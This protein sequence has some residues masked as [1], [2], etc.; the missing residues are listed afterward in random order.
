M[1]RCLQSASLGLISLVWILLLPDLCGASPRRVLF[2][3]S[4]HPG[5]PTFF[6]QVEGITAVL[7][8][9]KILLDVEFMDTKR[10]PGRETLDLFYRSLSRKI[11]RL[12]PYDAII[13]GDDNAL[14]FAL[15]HQQDLFAK[16]PIVFF[17][18]NDVD[19]A[20]E[21]IGNPLVTGTV[22]AVSMQETLELM[23]RLHP[24][25]K[26]VFALVDSTPSGQGDL[27][28][29]QRLRDEMAPV[30]LAEISLTDLSFGE[31]GTRLRGLGEADLVLLLSAYNDSKGNIL[32]FDQSLQLI[33]QNLS[34]PLYHLWYHGIGEGIFG[35]KVI[36]H[37]EQGR[38]AAGVVLEIFEGRPVSEIA[39]R[40]ASPNH[41][42]FDY[43]ELQRFGL[44][45]KDLPEDSLILN[46][47]SSFYQ[48]YK[49][50][51][52]AGLGVILALAGVTCA[53]S[54]HIYYRRQ[55]E[56][57]LRKSESLF[58]GLIDFSPVP[59]A[60]NSPDGRVEYLNSKFVQ[61]FGYSRVDIPDVE[62]WWIKA[63]PDENYRSGVMARWQEAI[64]EAA[65]DGSEIQPAEYLV[66]CKDGSTR[67]VEIFGALIGDKYLIVLNDI[68]DRKQAEEALQRALTETEEGRDK[69]AAIL[70]SV[71][72]GL[73]FTDMDNRVVLMSTSAQT[74]LGKSLH[75]IF[76]QPLDAVIDNG[77]LREQFTALHQGERNQALVE[78]SLGAE[79][80]EEVRTVQAKS[81]PVRRGS[82]VRAGVIT[83]LR[84][85]TLERKLDAMKNEFISTAAHELRTPLT[86]VK[87]FADLLLHEKGFSA[88][89][90]DEYLGIIFEKSQVL[91]EIIDDLLDLS[92]VESGRLV[93]LEKGLCDLVAVV[94]RSIDQYR[95][96][97]SS[98]RFEA[99]LPLGGLRLLLDE[100][101]MVQVMENLL[102]NAVKFSTRGGLIRI[103]C[104]GAGAE[105]RFSVED[106]GIGMTPEQIDRVFDK[107][108]RADTSDTAVGGL[109]LGMAIVKSIIEAHGG[110]IWVESKSGKGTKVSFTIPFSVQ[111]TVE[112]GAKME[113][114]RQ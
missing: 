106:Q 7:E 16:R 34:R 113:G 19:L 3:S 27:K 12:A 79:G 39:V 30:E 1:R 59:M 90:Q 82:G 101:K 80:E 97:F 23:A 58:R 53:L 64:A 10:F 71:A 77:A 15:E 67:S 100:G 110:R 52:W 22:E 102:S 66:T 41:Y 76:L 104:E 83:I 28:T 31:M 20:R 46:R 103:I 55:F 56:E 92:R 60:L 21:Q 4:Y 24:G 81:S 69:I 114:G 73:I 9:R 62:S 78:M 86:S 36:S 91:E 45:L 68:T 111:D 35:G 96:E 32:L 72:D 95:K 18:V 89:Q 13:T 63:Y 94:Q 6:Q 74:M 25:V 61:T 43:L 44:S 88:Q 57:A 85:V 38:T 14:A 112:M 40:Q 99:V 108:Y 37:F 84:D 11:S 48:V 109:G 107:F 29:F 8:P 54:R 49:A 98:H 87:G 105:V 70:N 47:P 5:F 51:L 17:G 50:Y 33:R 2:I 65:R 75:E 42:V 93:H 26:R